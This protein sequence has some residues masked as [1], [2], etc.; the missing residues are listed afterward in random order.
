M[1]LGI[2]AHIHHN[3]TH[4]KQGFLKIMNQGQETWSYTFTP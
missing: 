3:I 1:I 4:T 2:P